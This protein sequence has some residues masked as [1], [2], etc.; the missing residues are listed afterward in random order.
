MNLFKRFEA[1][2]SSHGSVGSGKGLAS[3]II[4]FVLAALSLLGVLAFRFPAYLT[5]PELRHA[6]DVELLRQ[7]MRSAMIVAG[8]ISVLNII[9]GRRRWLSFLSFLIL[10]GAELLG[11]PSVPVAD[12]PDHTPYL[13]IDWL[14]LD[15][16]GSAVL[17]IFIEKLF[18]LKKDQP[19]FR[20]DWQ[21]DFHYFAFSHLLVGVVFLATNQAV[22]H[23]LA[24]AVNADVQG[25]I[26]GLPFPVELLLILLVAD[27]TQYW[28][29]RAYH[30]VPVLWR[31]H[32]VHHSV[33]HMD[34][35]AGSRLHVLELLATRVGVFA[36]VFLLGFSK[37]TV[38]AYVVIVG[39][40]AVFNHAN[41]SVRLGPLSYLIVT[42]NFHHK[43]YAA[44][45]EI[46]A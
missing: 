37:D 26:Q 46:G 17:F 14:I 6:Y 22:N 35:I 31:L 23:G 27:L 25:W 39:F 28:L 32:S 12:F 13:G 2:A 44:D 10:M 1:P 43:T 18:G 11:G 45:A 33:K 42:P 9:L 21:T 40:Q 29:H 30:E 16:L 38:A 41:V 4:A 7:L 34:W 36:P 3:G 8:T 24:W 20:E 5:T 15:L 19:V